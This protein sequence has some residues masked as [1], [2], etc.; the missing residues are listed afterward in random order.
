MPPLS[1]E[2]HPSAHPIEDPDQDGEMSGRET[3]LYCM[4]ADPYDVIGWT[5]VLSFSLT[6]F[7]VTPSAAFC[8]MSAHKIVLGT[9]AS[10]ATSTCGA[11]TAAWGKTLSASSEGASGSNA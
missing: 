9:F 1:R 6:L 8:G 10:A 5:S 2:H 11:V 4:E 7:C 3:Y